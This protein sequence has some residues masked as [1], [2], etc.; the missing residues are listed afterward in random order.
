MPNLTKIGNARSVSRANGNPHIKGGLGAFKLQGNPTT[1]YILSQYHHHYHLL[2]N[3]LGMVEI[4]IVSDSKFVHKSSNVEY[5]YKEDIGLWL[6]L[7]KDIPSVCALKDKENK[8]F[9]VRTR[10]LLFKLTIS[11][12]QRDQN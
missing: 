1:I 3:Q 5:T 11:D 8:Y 10:E 9:Y 4:N 6:T 12:V 7:L 2:Y